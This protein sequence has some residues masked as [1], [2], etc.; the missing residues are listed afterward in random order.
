MSSPS[1][2]LTATAQDEPN[3][4]AQ[5]AKNDDGQKR[6]PVVHT[7]QLS[8]VA[9]QRH[10]LD[11][12]M[13][14]ANVPVSLPEVHRKQIRPPPD[15]VK[16]TPGSSA[17][18]SSSDFHVYRTYRRHETARLKQLDE[19]VKEEQTRQQYEQKRLATQQELEAQTAKKRAKRQRRKKSTNTNTVATK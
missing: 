12:L 5:P 16:N 2:K 13:A 10:Q 9:R 1:T 7:D 11:K 17:G 19:E 15:I 18:A 8:A 3:A 4:G 6:V 14:K